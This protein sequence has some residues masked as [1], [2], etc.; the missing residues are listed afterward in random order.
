MT[1]EEMIEKYQGVL[2]TGLIALWKEK[3]LGNLKDGYF[4]L[5]NPDE[6]IEILKDTYFRGNESYPI[7]VTAFGDIITWEEINILEL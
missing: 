1:L 4:Q 6:Y 5:I 2:P 3:G 7:M